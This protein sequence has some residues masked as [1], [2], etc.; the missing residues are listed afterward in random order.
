MTVISCL[1][2]QNYLHRRWQIVGIPIGHPSR[3]DAF[4]SGSH[5]NSAHACIVSALDVDLFIADKKRAGKIDLVLSLGFE[6]HAGLGLA[7]GG[8]L[9]GTICAT[10]SR[11]DQTIP[12]L[13]QQR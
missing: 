9:A 11:I 6:D 7:T 12:N 10:V 13:A 3:G 2:P 8:G 4:K 5:T 1:R